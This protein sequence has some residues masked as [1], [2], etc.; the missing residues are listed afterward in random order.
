MTPRH[1]QDPGARAE[2]RP[3]THDAARPGFPLPGLQREATVQLSCSGTTARLRPDG[4]GRGG[5]VLDIGEAAQSH[6][7]PAH[8]EEILY[9][10]LRRIAHLADA[11]KAPG[12][13]VRAAHLGAGAMTLPRYIAA[14]RPGSVQVAV[15]IEREL[16]GFVTHHL[17]LPS[18]ARL[19]VVHDD[20]RAALP[21]LACAAGLA[22]EPNTPGCFDLVV[23]D[24]FSGADSPEHLACREFYAEALAQ[25]GPG[26]ILAV[27]V[28]DDPGL[29]FYAAQ[30]EAMD[31]AARTQDLSGA[32]T[33]TDAGMLGGTRAGNLILAIGPGLEHGEGHE[34]W[35]ARLAARGPHPAAVLD[36]QGTRDLARELSLR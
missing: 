31:Q 6:V 1:R 23:T 11:V 32:W 13:P 9:E 3:E 24:I 36:A 5:V 22:A 8:P 10:Y 18:G 17:P 19:H 34:E 29:H 7:D 33:L 30:A 35:R 4:W 28:G 20:A 25:V 15:E 21:T 2:S 16:P 27:N 14:T 26:G 12:E